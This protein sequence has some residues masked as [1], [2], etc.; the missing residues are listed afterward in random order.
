MLQQSQNPIGMLQGMAGNNPIVGRALQMTMGKNPMELQQIAQNLANQ[1]G[2][3]L[4][5]FLTSMGFRR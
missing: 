5:Q 3:D 1:R 2:V 4:S